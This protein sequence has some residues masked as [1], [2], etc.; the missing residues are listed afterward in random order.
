MFIQRTFFGNY[1]TYVLTSA[2]KTN[3]TNK[4]SNAI[5]PSRA[6]P[7]PP[8]FHA[9][10]FPS[11]LSDNEH[12]LT[13]NKTLSSS[14]LLNNA[15]CYTTTTDEP[16]SSKENN[17]AVV[18]TGYA[19]ALLKTSSSATAP[20]ALKKSSS[21]VSATPRDTKKHIKTTATANRILSHNKD[22]AHVIPT[23]KLNNNTRATITKAQA[24]DDG[25]NRTATTDE[26]S[27][28]S[29]STSDIINNVSVESSSTTTAPTPSAP[30]PVSSILWS[31]KKSFAD[32]LKKQQQL[33]AQVGF[34]N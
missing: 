11:L 5:H 6:M 31:G 32:V 20:I 24:A 4:L 33:D 26:K 13:D 27:S 25:S 14:S 18:T 1:L 3:Y 23:S 19:A 8:Q 16:L 17:N 21:S 2:N 10:Q 22:N 12:L 29:S 28:I 9:S 15:E 30:S 7:P 34:K